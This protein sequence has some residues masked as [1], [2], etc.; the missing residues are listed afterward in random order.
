MCFEGEIKDSIALVRR[1]YDVHETVQSKGAGIE[2]DI[3]LKKAI[4][5]KDTVPSA[6]PTTVNI[7]MGVMDEV[8][9][10]WDIVQ[11]QFKK[12]SNS[13]K[14]EAQSKWKKM[15]NWAALVRGKLVDTVKT[16]KGWAK[17]IKKDAKGQWEYLLREA[18]H[19]TKA[20]GGL[21][22]CKMPP[23]KYIAADQTMASSG[24]PDINTA[25]IVLR[26][27]DAVTDWVQTF[28]SNILF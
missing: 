25:Y 3:Y 5:A 16:F 8:S 2:A 4:V 9:K 27:N 22:T 1:M 23:R 15:A 11:K 10:D 18:H 19:A 17:N 20:I 6:F 12:F 21:L 28:V 26:G 13:L 7:D 24:V 14:T